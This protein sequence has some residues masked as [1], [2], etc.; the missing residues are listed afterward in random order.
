MFAALAAVW[1]GLLLVA[2]ALVGRSLTPP[3]L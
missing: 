2:I 1:F 3:V